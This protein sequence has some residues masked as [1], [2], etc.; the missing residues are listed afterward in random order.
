M[1]PYMGALWKFP[2]KKKAEI[3]FNP[4][5]AVDNYSGYVFYVRLSAEGDFSYHYQ[6]VFIQSFIF[7][8]PASKYLQY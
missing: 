7:F 6:N 2:I 1:H 3:W 8:F 4:F 5:T